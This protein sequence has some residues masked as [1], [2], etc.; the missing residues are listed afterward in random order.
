MDERLE[1]QYNKIIK[2]INSKNSLEKR[3]G[4]QAAGIMMDKYKDQLP[5]DK[6]ELLFDHMLKEPE[7]F[8][9]YAH[10]NDFTINQKER[11]LQAYNKRPIMIVQC[12][13][14]THRMFSS[15]A[16]LEFINEHKFYLAKTCF[17]R[18]MDYYYSVFRSMK[19]DRELIDFIVDTIFFQKRKFDK[20]FLDSF[21]EAIEE[22]KI[23]T[24]QENYDKLVS[25][26]VMMELA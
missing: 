16:K 19:N 17:R 4:Y 13:A 1:S 25:C 7:S 26:Q 23:F 2:F 12:E 3:K 18:S 22:K 15:K 20:H 24:S 5:I 6:Q 11:I 10:N 8:E 14:L 9:E 21:I